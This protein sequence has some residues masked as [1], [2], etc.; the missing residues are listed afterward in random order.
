VTAKKPRNGPPSILLSCPL[1]ISTKR[2][3][4]MPMSCGSSCRNH[5]FIL[6]V[7][8]L[9]PTLFKTQCRYL[10]LLF[11]SLNSAAEVL[12]AITCLSGSSSLSYQ[13]FLRLSVY[14]YF[15][16]LSTQVHEL[17]KFLSQSHVYLGRPASHTN[18]F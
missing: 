14:L 9:K 18:T 8:P 11:F 6:V 3:C 5:M 15:F 4:E 17:R 10:S 1:R 12:V 16:S 2:K 7:Q 13:H